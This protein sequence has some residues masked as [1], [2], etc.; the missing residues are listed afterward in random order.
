MIEQVHVSRVNLFPFGLFIVLLFLGTI[1]AVGQPATYSAAGADDSPA[2]V[3][4]RSQLKAAHPA[5][6][7]RF[8]DAIH[9]MGSPLIEPVQGEKHYSFVTFVWRGT[10]QTQ[11]VVIFDGVAAFDAKDRMQQ[12][13]STKIWYKTYRVRNDAR[14]AYNLSP[15]DSLQPFDQIKG[16]DAMKQRLAALQ[17]DPLNPHRC[18][19]TFGA[20][21]AESSF[22]ELPEAEP[23]LWSS[24]LHAVKRGKLEQKQIHSLLLQRDKKLWVYTPADYE[25]GKGAYPLLVLFDGD[26]NSMW[27]PQI[28]DLMIAQGQ[29]PPLIVVMTDESTPSIRTSELTCNQQFADFLAEELVPWLRSGY[30]V[31]HSP[32]ETLV[33]G[34]SLGGLAAV[35]AGLK[36]PEIFGN[37]IS[38]SGSFWWKPQGEVQGEWLTRLVTNSTKVA[39]RFYLEVGLMESLP[40]QIETNRHMQ[41]ALIAKQYPTGYAEFDGGHSFLTWSEGM[42][43][44]LRYAMRSPQPSQP[45]S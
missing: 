10:T 34:S 25:A 35:F 26:R 4:L 37:V 32:G 22:V 9:R 36:H 18:P 11:N 7:D 39:S 29:I 19:A 40:I 27:I 30:A 21:D 6:V 12:I 8:W 3:H 24:S 42:V 44:G 23:L 41:Q 33:S 20:Y 28:L 5:A 1:G 15:N 31:T 2:I 43:H 17:I 14:F 38:L 45:A 16:D 13:G